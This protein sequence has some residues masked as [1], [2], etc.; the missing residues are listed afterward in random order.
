MA[1][2]PPKRG[3]L[4]GCTALAAASCQGQ[5]STWSAVADDAAQISLLGNIMFVG[6]TVILALVV[7]LTALA[8]NGRPAS[9]RPISSERMVFWGGVVFPVVTLSALLIYGLLLTGA[10]GRSSEPST[11]RIDVTGEQFWWRVH[12]RQADGQPDFATANEIHIP[13]GRT[14][15]LVMASP[16]VIHSFWVPNIAGKLD[17]VPGQQ[18]RMVIK[19]SEPI[20]ARGQCAE[21]C[22]A[23]HANMS[24]HLI[25]RPEADFAGWLAGQRAEALQ[26]AETERGRSLFLSAGCGGCHTIRGTLARG[27]IG[28]DLTHFGGR[29]FLGAGMMRN[30]AAAI[31]RWI[32]SAQHIK[33]GNKM[34]SFGIFKPDD[35]T[36]LASYLEGLK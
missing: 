22:G 11:L 35:L 28:P 2:D 15:E 30:D 27:T 31:A 21:F 13:A 12:Y 36:A 7:I 32:S 19:A 18:N 24:L 1:L 9:R 14:V 23:Q 6:G 4:V 26:N 33:P 5:Q 8:I 25:A 17:M 29:M 20:V 3:L 34:P 16:D 10:V